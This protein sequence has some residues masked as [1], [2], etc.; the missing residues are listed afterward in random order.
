MGK[1]RDA[2]GRF[3]KGV[4]GNPG[5]RPKG[6]AATV[7]E[8]TDLDALLRVL[9]GIVADT[10]CRAADRIR[11]AELVLDRGWGKAPAYAPIADGDPLE[12]S[13]I[14]R[15]IRDIADQLRQTSTRAEQN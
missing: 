9:L 12:G 11:A 8:A 10:A 7:R 5:G 6:L 15:A 13:E 1:V 3:E 4:S 14:D 2:R